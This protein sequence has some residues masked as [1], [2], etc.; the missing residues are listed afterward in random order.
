[1]VDFVIKLGLCREVESGARN[2]AL[3][4]W[5]F[6]FSSN[7]EAFVE[8]PAFDIAL[9]KRCKLVDLRGLFLCQE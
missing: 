7:R 5:Y 3:F 6:S 2:A 4:D 9:H 1:M 8:K